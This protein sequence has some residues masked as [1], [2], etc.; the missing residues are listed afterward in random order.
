MYPVPQ[1][2]AISD[3]KHRH[4][5]VFKRLKNGPVVLANRSQPTAVL[6]APE[7]WN[8]IIKYIDDLECG[9]EALQTELA[10]AKGEDAF[11]RLTPADIQAWLG[12]DV[13]SG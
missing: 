1:M 6:I 7:K 5:E 4:L 8:A 2:A 10:I 11:E 3:L 13:V 12:D 9:I